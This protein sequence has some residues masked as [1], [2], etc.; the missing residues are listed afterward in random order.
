MGYSPWGC[1]ES[2]TTEGNTSLNNI[3]AVTLPLYSSLHVSNFFFFA[4]N[5]EQPCADAENCS[6]TFPVLDN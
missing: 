4:N 6:I 3:V 1:K 2:D 5:V